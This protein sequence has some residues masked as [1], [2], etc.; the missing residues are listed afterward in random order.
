MP[1]KRKRKRGAIHTER[2]LLESAV[3]LYLQECY[4]AQ[5][6]ARTSELA[7]RLRMSPKHLTREIARIAGQTP[8]GFLRSRQL[9]Y[10]AKLLRLTPLTLPEIALHSGFGTDRTLHRA[11]KRS[12][13]MT[14][15]EY[16]NK[17]K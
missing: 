5:T 6:P 2:Q 10:A 13:A 17:V 8:H 14:P 16:R 12:F 9:E 7:Q 3:A 4:E 11:F 1:G 15:R